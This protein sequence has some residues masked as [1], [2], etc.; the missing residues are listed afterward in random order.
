MLINKK[1]VKPEDSYHENN[2][3]PTNWHKNYA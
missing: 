3:A 1:T 2:V